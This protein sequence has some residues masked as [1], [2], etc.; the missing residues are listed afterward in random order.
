MWL[1]VH[2][3]LESH[4]VEQVDQSAQHRQSAS[5]AADPSKHAISQAPLGAK[6]KS[7]PEG[8][9]QA[10]GEAAAQVDTT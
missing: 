8:D 1:S 6:R 2:Y 9:R 4:T 7:R 5:E 3:L 10:A